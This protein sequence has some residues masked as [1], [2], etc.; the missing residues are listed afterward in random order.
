[1]GLS[2]LIRI[3]TVSYGT[4]A[5]TVTDDTS[6]FYAGAPLFEAFL[7]LRELSTIVIVYTIPYGTIAG[8]RLPV[9]PPFE[10]F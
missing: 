8:T 9:I 1:M 5:G 2:A 6:I 4:I 10:T 7:V 3:Y